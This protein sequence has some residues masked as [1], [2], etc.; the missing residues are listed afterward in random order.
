MQSFFAHL[1]FAC[2]SFVH[3]AT[4]SVVSSR[5]D[6]RPILTD[7]SN[8]WTANTVVSFPEDPDFVN[9]TERWTIYDS[10]SYAAAVTPA[11]EADV[12]KAVTLSRT[13][14]V[15]FLAT[16]GH[17]G[18]TTTLG[19]LQAG[20][21]IDMSQLNSVTIDNSAATLTIGGGTRFRDIMDPIYAAGFDIRKLLSGAYSSNADL[22]WGI[23]GA[24]ANLGVIVSAT[25]K[26]E[27]LA[28]GG[29]LTSVDVMFPASM[30]TS[31]FNALQ[32]YNG[33]IPAKLAASTSIAYNASTGEAEILAS[34]I[35]SGTREEAL[36]AMAPMLDLNP[37]LVSI[38]DVPWNQMNS[39]TGFG[40]DAVTCEPD[41]TR[42]LYGVN[43]RTLSAST[44]I[45][46]FNKMA[47]FYDAF[48]EAQSS[49]I[50]I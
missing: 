1:T 23:R 47:T 3:V 25:Y 20:L 28:N 10:P 4:T 37:P 30:N 16:G 12:V 40:L 2:L 36:E 29:I 9:A 22:F 35:Y 33:T 8:Y 31:Y 41:K 43:L 48:P 46:T 49:S 5:T 39:A 14:A 13:H 26:P 17:H 50:L 15:P 44:C 42:S 38:S 34:W 24:G 11:T 21:A 45:S 32:S 7:P 18:Y 27:P 19:G 6:L